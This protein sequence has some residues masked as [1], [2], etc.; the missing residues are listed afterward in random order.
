MPYQEL[1]T[2]R[3]QLLA[4]I[5]A[6]LGAAGSTYRT[7][8]FSMAIHHKLLAIIS[9]GDMAQGAT[10]DATLLEATDAA[11]TGAKVITAKAITQLTAIGGDSND[12]LAINLRTEEMDA[13]NNFDHVS[14]RIRVGTATVNFSAMVLG[15]V[16][17]YAPV[18]Q[19]AWT[20]VVP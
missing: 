13:A 6:D 14:L 18:S 2:E 17:R 7:P 4:S 10:F 20:E 19:I 12:A 9:V 1:D 11:G 5:H 16:P 15:N 3:M 8:Y